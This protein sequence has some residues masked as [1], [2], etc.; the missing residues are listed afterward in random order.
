MKYHDSVKEDIQ[1]PT[2]IRDIVV[3]PVMTCDERSKRQPGFGRALFRSICNLPRNE[4]YTCDTVLDSEMDLVV[5]EI[6]VA[7][8]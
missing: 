2:K 7:M 8:V 6:P 3:K 4:T 1:S 5:S